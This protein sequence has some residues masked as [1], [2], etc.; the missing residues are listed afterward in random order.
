MK[1]VRMLVF[2]LSLSTIVGCTVG[3]TVFYNFAG[4]NDYKKFPSR[5]LAPSAEKFT[6]YPAVQPLTLESIRLYDQEYPFEQLLLENKTVAFLVIRNDTILYE[7]YFD[8]YDT[9]DVVPSFSM[10]KSVIS[11]LVGC[12][13]DDGYIR[14]VDE[15]VTEYVPELSERGFDEVTIR[16]VLQMTSGLD[17]NE[18]YNNPFG[19]AATYYYG[20][21][22]RK[23]ISKMELKRPSGEAF[24]Y[25]S[26]NSQ[27]LGLIV[28]RAVR[29]KSVTDYLHE[30]IWT[31]LGAEYP[32]SWSIDK[33]KDGIEKTFCC[34]NATARDFAK[35]GR[36]YLRNGN[37][38]GQQLVSESWVKESIAVDSTAGSAPYYQYQ[39]WLPSKEGDFMAVGILGQYI[40]VNPAK[41]LIIV[42]LGRKRGKVPWSKVFREL[43]TRK[44]V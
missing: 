16:H 23:Y 41:N 28:E 2:A 44:N 21:H 29:D 25:V 43:A 40:Y 30:K 31:H 24:E 39:W 37:W 36:L 20:R 26:G 27:L 7:K 32:A 4:I 42:R 38:N 11:M 5:D 12:A 19:E 33:K 35:I 22:L 13:I 15:P 6:F 1:A 3:R 10:A 14:S 18:S 34:I 8:G 9:P 17:F